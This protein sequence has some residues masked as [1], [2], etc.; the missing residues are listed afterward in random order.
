MF[1]EI[2]IERRGF[3]KK[4]VKFSV[5]VCIVI[6]LLTVIT[7]T[8]F[9]ATVDVIPGQVQI[10]NS[11]GTGNFAEGVYTATVTSN[12]KWI[13]S[14]NNITI[15]NNSSNKA[16]ISFNYKAEGYSSFSIPNSSNSSGNYSVI[17]EG[18][19]SVKITIKAKNATATLTL[20]DISYT[21]VASEIDVNI[22]YDNTLGEVTENGASVE[23][24]GNVVIGNAGVE[25]TAT[26]ING[27]EF[28]GWVDEKGFIRSQSATYTQFPDMFTTLEALFYKDS[29]PFFMIDDKYI[30]NDL[31]IAAQSGKKVV[32]MRDAVLPAGNYTIPSGT[33]L[34]IPFDAANT[35]Y[36]TKPGSD[37][38]TY[39]NV[40]PKPYKTLTMVNGTNITVN[41]AISISAK[42]S[43]KIGY[44]GA[45]VGAY[46]LV[47]MEDGSAITVNSGGNLYVWGYIAGSGKITAKSGAT[48]YEDFQVRDWRGGDATSSMID[49]PQRVFPMSQYYVQNI[50]VP[51]TLEAGAVEN[52]YMSITVTVL[53]VQGSAIPFVGPNGMFRI[54]S[55][56]ITKDYDEATDRLVIDV[57][58]T[59]DMASLSLSMNLGLLVGT[60]TVNSQNYTLPINGNITLHVN[61]GS[62]INISQEMALLPGGVINVYGG[63]ECT[64]SSGSKIFI[65][66]GDEWGK[67]HYPHKNEVTPAAYA[68]NRKYT[69]SD[70]DVVD[71]EIYIEGIVDSYAGNVYITKSGANIHGA[72]GGL[73]K[74][75]P[76]TETTVTYYAT[77]DSDKNVSFHEIPVTTAKIKNADG[78]YVDPELIDCSFEYKY[79]NGKWIPENAEHTNIVVTEAIEPTCT[80][81]GQTEGSQCLTCGTVIQELEELSALGHDFSAEWTIDIEPTCTT[82][83]SKSHHCTRCS[84]KSD[85]TTIDMLG[86]S[87]GDWIKVDG[88]THKRICECEDVEVVPHTFVGLYCSEC[89]CEKRVTSSEYR[90]E[91]E[92]LIIN[93]SFILNVPDNTQIII[94]T[95]NS[96]GKLLNISHRSRYLL[97]EIT[98]PATDVAKIKVFAWD[99]FDT[100]APISFIEEIEI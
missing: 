21:A 90:I 22:K 2:R 92:K 8:V 88:N 42:Q 83:G 82:D 1:G 31:N 37:E 46:G 23:A 12:S 47:S 43:C 35:M 45:P 58:G 57:D 71:A 17:L 24:N 69:R 28:I 77:Q 13:A 30:F 81:A 32:L 3:M 94:A 80:N 62:K 70:S 79:S 96:S 33:T 65:Y 18:G 39:T 89:G 60:K 76:D 41:G 73:V 50:Q 19:G 86:H 27:A 16:E 49:K 84:E 15:I 44:N 87:Y 56:S 75:K 52:G 34:L 20:T 40:K 59:L 54:N 14:T 5:L 66:D 51:L 29:K 61:S 53:G 26:P 38:S 97:E 36:D 63:A 6:T 100:M 85:V 78:K 48:V 74:I 10:T 7:G 11:S 67:Y 91:N 64:V 95:Y 99:G 4:V 55:G 93:T 68:H 72:E 98:L 9:A 25:L